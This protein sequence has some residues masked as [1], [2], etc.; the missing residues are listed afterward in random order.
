MGAD[1]MPLEKKQKPSAQ[2]LFQSAQTQF[3]LEKSFF[4]FALTFFYFAQTCINLL[5]NKK[6]RRLSILTMVAGTF[7]FGKIIFPVC[8]DAIPISKIG[9]LFA[10]IQFP[11]AKSFS[12]LRR[13][14]SNWKIIVPICAD[15]ILIG[16]I[17]FLIDEDIKQMAETQIPLAKR[18]FPSA[19]IRNT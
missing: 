15:T 4:H 11:F 3:Q 5:K 16:K 2:T 19:K 6:M 13:G 18:Q 9:F 14:N 17:V 10:R 8:E 12:R 1:T 7:P